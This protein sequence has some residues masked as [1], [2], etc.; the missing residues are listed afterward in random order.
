MVLE[1][2]F[3][4]NQE[5][6]NEKAKVINLFS[7]EE[8]EQRFKKSTPAKIISIFQDKYNDIEKS[9]KVEKAINNTN[10]AIEKMVNYIFNKENLPKNIA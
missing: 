7:K 3:H 8:L 1:N 2:N 9:K 5:N 4:H 6:S 10:Q